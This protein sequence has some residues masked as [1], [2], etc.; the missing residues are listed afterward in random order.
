VVLLQL[1]LEPLE[2]GEGIGGRAGEAA[3]HRAV[4]ADPAHLARVRLQHRLPERHLAVAGN[5]HLAVLADRQDRRAMPFDRIAHLAPASFR[6]R[7]G[8]E[9]APLQ[10]TRT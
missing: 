5:R 8:G 2:Q 7:Y 1:L 4:A 10:S 6:R 9:G 3:D